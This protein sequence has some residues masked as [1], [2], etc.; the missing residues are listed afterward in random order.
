M[1]DRSSF[2]VLRFRF[3]LERSE[4][5]CFFD[6]MCIFILLFCSGFEFLLVISKFLLGEIKVG[7][8][9]IRGFIYI[10]FFLFYCGFMIFV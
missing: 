8:I 10:V 7:R 9:E 1:E 5:S 6:Y 3:N 4:V 2:R